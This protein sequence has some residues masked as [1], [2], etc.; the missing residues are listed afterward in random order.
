MLDNY[1]V[2]DSSMSGITQRNYLFVL[3]FFVFFFQIFCFDIEKF[4]II[5]RL[6]PSRKVRLNLYFDNYPVLDSL[7]SFIILFF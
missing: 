1:P 7:I 3:I 4:E 6:N 5:N 2:L